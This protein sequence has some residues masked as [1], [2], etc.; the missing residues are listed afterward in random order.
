MNA[1]EMIKYCEQELAYWEKMIAAQWKTIEEKRKLMPEHKLTG[2]DLTYH[3]Y[4]G[5]FNTYQSMLNKLNK[6]R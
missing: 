4:C 3:T 5:N 6:G 2:D 1:Q